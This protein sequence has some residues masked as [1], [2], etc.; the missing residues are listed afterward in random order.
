MH[1]HGAI[2]GSAGL[3]SQSKQMRHGIVFTGA[4]SS[5]ITWSSDARVGEFGWDGGLSTRKEDE[6]APCA[7]RGGEIKMRSI[8]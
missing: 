5:A 2:K 3:S 7:A 6:R 4:A 8:V 1:K